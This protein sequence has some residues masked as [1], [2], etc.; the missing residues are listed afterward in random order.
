MIKKTEAGTEYYT[1]ER[2]YITELHNTEL[3]PSVSIASARVTPGVTTAWHSVSST[4]ERY[5]IT[6]GKGC[7]ETDD[8]CGVFLNVGDSII[9]PAGA[10][11]RIRNTGETDLIFLC[12]CTPRFDW[13][14][15]NSFEN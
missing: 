13:V 10:R 9:I 14:N 7:A 2:C 5:L 6:H 4:E 8:T 3:D 15:Y 11:Q 1:K 12:I